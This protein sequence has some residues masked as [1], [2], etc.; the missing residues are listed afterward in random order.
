MQKI[1]APKLINYKYILIKKLL[2]NNGVIDY[3]NYKE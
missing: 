1:K 2:L 3:N